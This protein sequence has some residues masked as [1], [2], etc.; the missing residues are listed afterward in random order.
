M[1][2]QSRTAHKRNA[3]PGPGAVT[4]FYDRVQRVQT[5]A[6]RLSQRPPWQ[7]PDASFGIAPVMSSRSTLRKEVAAANLMTAAIGI[8]G[9]RAAFG[10]GHQAAVDAVV[11]GIGADDEHVPVARLRG[12]RQ[13]EAQDGGKTDHKG[14]H[15]LAPVLAA[16]LP[17]PIIEC[18]Q[19]R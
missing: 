4:N 10:P 2:L 6:T 15:G 19:N 17:A 1:F 13:A 16:R 5:I 11:A 7:P 18:E 8:G 14:A 3:R 12:G 9:G